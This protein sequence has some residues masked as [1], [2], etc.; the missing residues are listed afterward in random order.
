MPTYLP[1]ILKERRNEVTDNTFFFLSRRSDRGGGLAASNVLRCRGGRRDRDDTNDI[2]R[3]R[4]LTRSAAPRQSRRPSRHARSPGASVPVLAHAA[5]SARRGG[6]KCRHVLP[7]VRARAREH[8]VSAPGRAREALS[9]QRARRA[10]PRRRDYLS[11]SRQGLTRAARAR[12]PSGTYHTDGR[13][14]RAGYLRMC[15]AGD[16]LS[17]IGATTTSDITWYHGLCSIIC[18]LI[19]HICLGS[20]YCWFRKGRGWHFPTDPGLE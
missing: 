11:W 16:Q 1:R 7:V 2:R 14:P 17:S 6:P 20:M 3:A 5:R 9:L 13:A 12:G 18:I 19:F 10:R 4:A 8:A 15:A